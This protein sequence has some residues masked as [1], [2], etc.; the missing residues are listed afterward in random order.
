MK[1]IFTLALTALALGWTSNVFAQ[2]EEDVTNYISN[3]GFDEDL[4]FQADGTWKEAVNKQSL[5]NR[6]EAW[7]AEDE[8]VYGHTKATSTET[9][10][11]GLKEKAVNGFI[12]RIKGWEIETNQT[13][14][15]CEWVYFGSVPYA[16][17]EKAVPIA[18]NGD[19]YLAVPAKPDEDSGEDNV[20]AVYLRAGWGGACSYKQTVSLPCAQYRLDYWIY[21]FNYEGSKNNTKVKN[22]CKVICRKDVFED[23]DGFN[24]QEWTK[25][26]IEFTPTSEFSIQFGFQ[27]DGGS[28][29]NP[30]LFIDG[31]KLYKIGEA[32]RAEILQADLY[33]L[34]IALQEFLG[35]EP[36]SNYNGLI[37]EIEDM[38][39]KANDAAEEDDLDKMESTFNEVDAYRQKLEALKTTLEEFVTAID[40]AETFYTDE[41]AKDNPY[42]GI[43]QLS[44]DIEAIKTKA[45]EAGS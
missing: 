44:T 31:I 13:F 39:Q 12:G 21:N 36:F 11:D 26:S 10:A 41:S 40:D 34:G 25:H 35:E 8:T 9:R 20:G 22:L 28:G 32:D 37:T 4:T 33:D 5:T 16:L 1:K 30:Y 18:D 3:P 6:T 14:P 17:E 7:I 15:Q 45:D 23:T 2:E 27:S 43:D 24:A 42:P 38:A 29:S 19:T